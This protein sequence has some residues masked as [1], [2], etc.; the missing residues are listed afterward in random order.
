MHKNSAKWWKVNLHQVLQHEE[1]HS[2]RHS[3]H[4][5]C[6]ELGVQFE[7]PC[8]FHRAKDQHLRPDQALESC[9]ALL[10]DFI[11]QIQ[12]ELCSLRSISERNDDAPKHYRL[13]GAKHQAVGQILS[14]PTEC[15]GILLN[16]LSIFGWDSLGSS[17]PDLVPYSFN[18]RLS[19]QR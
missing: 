3:A 12:I 11:L 2:R 16:T 13:I 17:S 9:S 15:K 7:Q 18:F 6:C 4:S 5:Q 14:L 19:L 10:A 1:E 8:N